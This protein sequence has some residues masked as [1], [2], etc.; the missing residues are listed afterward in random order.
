LVFDAVPSWVCTQCGEVYLEEP[1]V[2][3][4]QDAID[5]VDHSTE[6]FAATG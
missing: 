3:A 4:I 1:E 5:S 2:E 6:R